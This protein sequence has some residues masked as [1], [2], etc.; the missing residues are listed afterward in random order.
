MIKSH[1]V[2]IQ[3]RTASVGTEGEQ[4]FS[5]ATLKT[6]IADVQPVT[7][8]QAQIDAFGATDTAANAKKMFFASDATIVLFQR[9]TVSGEV[10]EI[11]GINVWPRHSEAIL[12]PI[13]G[14]GP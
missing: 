5:Y 4:N 2:L 10:Y 6:I 8:C 9:A 7:L 3:S 12:V 11:R 14:V 1:S 13:Q